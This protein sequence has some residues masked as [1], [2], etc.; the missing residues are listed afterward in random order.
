M[1]LQTIGDMMH[2]EMKSCLYV[3]GCESKLFDVD[4]FQ[5]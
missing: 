1:E 4:L 5:P 3:V 2:D